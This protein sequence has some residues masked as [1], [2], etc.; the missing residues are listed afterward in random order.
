MCFQS[1]RVGIPTQPLS[2]VLNYMLEC[3]VIVS[4]I[5]SSRIGTALAFFL[6]L[7]LFVDKMIVGGMYDFKKDEGIQL[8]V[9]N[10]LTLYSFPLERQ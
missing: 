8:Q 6:S 4:C 10:E 5:L 9:L 2:K 7:E 3:I 1:G